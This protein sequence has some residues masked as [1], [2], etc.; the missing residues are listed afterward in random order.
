MSFL[1]ILFTLLVYKWNK[2]IAGWDEDSIFFIPHITK[3]YFVVLTASYIIFKGIIKPK[4]RKI[5]L[6]IFE[7][8]YLFVLIILASGLI[9][10]WNYIFANFNVYS[11]FYIPHI[12]KIYIGSVFLLAVIYRGIIKPLRHKVKGSFLFPFQWIMVGLVGVSL[13]IVKAPGYFLGAV[14]E[15]MGKSISKKPQ[16]NGE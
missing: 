16:K 5:N 1:L 6:G 12:T 8:V 14:L 15:I 10:K 13:D 4:N 3:I 11:I 9:Y 7:R 2:V